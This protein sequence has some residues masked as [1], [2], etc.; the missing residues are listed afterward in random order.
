M[1][2]FAPL[3]TSY[4][5]GQTRHSTCPP[6]TFSLPGSSLG[7]PVFRALPGLGTVRP[8]VAHERMPFAPTDRREA[9]K[10]DIGATVIARQFDG[11]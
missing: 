6:T 7:M 8:A 5:A 2:R 10:P 1:M 11:L 9:I 4:N 3:T